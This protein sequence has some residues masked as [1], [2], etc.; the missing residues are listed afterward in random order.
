M[1]DDDSAYVICDIDDCILEHTGDNLSVGGFIATQPCNMGAPNANIGNIEGLSVVQPLEVRKT[2]RVF[3]FRLYLIT[4]SENNY[5]AS[6]SYSVTDS[7]GIVLSQG[8][9]DSANIAD[10]SYYSIYFE[11]PMEVEAGDRLYLELEINDTDSEPI[12]V[13]ITTYDSIENASLSVDDYEYYDYD[14]VV[15]FLIE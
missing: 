1:E 15:D 12:T 11:E 14:M 9:T 3:G 13:G 4:Y 7:N 10:N 2:G 5:V 6:I 8:E